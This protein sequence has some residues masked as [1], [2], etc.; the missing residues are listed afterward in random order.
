MV[1]EYCPGEDLSFHLARQ[2]LEENEARFFIAEII[3]ALEHL[4]NMD[5]IYLD[6]KPENILFDQ[7][8]HVKLADFGLVNDKMDLNMKAKTFRGSSTNLSLEIVKKIGYGKDADIYGIGA[9]LYEML[10]G[11][12]PVYSKINSLTND[13]NENKIIFPNYISKEARSF[14]GV[15]I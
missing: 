10:T 2:L 3:L 1:L 13:I 9:I 11:T 4:H 15:N 6:L 8:G 7:E 5:V 12:P 14:I